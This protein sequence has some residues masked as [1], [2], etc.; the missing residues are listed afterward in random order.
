MKTIKAILVLVVIVILLTSCV[1]RQDRKFN[2][3]VTQAKQHQDNL[4]Y[5]AA[6]EV[7]NKALEIKEDVDVRGTLVRLKTEVAQIQEVKT[8]VSKI[9]EQ[10]SQL[11]G[12]L[13]NKDVADLCGGLL[14]SLARLEN[15]DTSA[16]TAASEYVSNLKKSTTFR[17]LKVQIESAQVL[18]SGK[19]S[20]KIPYEA[21]EKV[22]KTATSLFDEF[23][24]PPSFSSAG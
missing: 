19:S 15:Y 18:S 8:M 10:T 1:S 7:Y 2:D 14:E 5:E 4:D 22:L 24:F 23:P 17:L 21:T 6:L 11:K 12:V 3:L 20:K 13:T 16:D 9:K